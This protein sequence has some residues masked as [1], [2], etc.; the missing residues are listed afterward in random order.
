MP[1]L[2]Q[3]PRPWT[4]TRSLISQREFHRQASFRSK[5]ESQRARGALKAVLGQGF[6][7]ARQVSGIALAV[8]RRRP[9]L[10]SALR[11][12]LTEARDQ[13]GGF[14]ATAI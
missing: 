9:L 14:A 12:W 3:K 13:R 4:A 8:A 6:K 10:P 1:F 5:P 2:D 11:E 7:R